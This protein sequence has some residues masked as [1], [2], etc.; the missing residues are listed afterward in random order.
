MGQEHPI[1][2]VSKVVDP[3][4]A[5]VCPTE[6]EIKEQENIY[7]VAVKRSIRPP[8]SSYLHFCHLLMYIEMGSMDGRKNGIS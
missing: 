4:A 2:Q 1:E 7:N 8:F 3:F 5:L 6:E